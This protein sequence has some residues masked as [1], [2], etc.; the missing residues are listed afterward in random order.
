MDVRLY[1]QRDKLVLSVRDTGVGIAPEHQ[2]RVFERLYRVDST[3]DRAT[4][5]SGLGLAIAARAARSLSGYID[6]ESA[7]GKGSEFRAVV[8]ARIK[9]PHN[10]AAEPAG[11][12]SPGNGSVRAPR[13]IPRSIRRG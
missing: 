4:G 13:P 5:G 8:P 10:Q 7:P 12:Q 2:Q 3:R 1:R 9:S 11:A 6:L